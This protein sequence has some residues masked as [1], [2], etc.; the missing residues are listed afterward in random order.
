MIHS[1]NDRVNSRHSSRPP[2]RAVDLANEIEFLQSVYR[3]YTE[4]IH[5]SQTD[6]EQVLFGY[7]PP[8]GIPDLVV[9]VMTHWVDRIDRQLDALV[10][11]SNAYAD[12]FNQRGFTLAELKMV[13]KG[14]VAETDYL[15]ERAFAY[16]YIHSPQE[17]R[18]FI[19]QHTSDDAD[20]SF[21]DI[22]LQL[23]ESWTKKSIPPLH[24]FFFGYS[25]PHYF[26]LSSMKRH[27]WILGKTGSGKSEIIKN[28][29]FH[30]QKK[31]NAKQDKSLVCIE[32]Q[33][34]LSVELLQ[35]YLNGHNKER[36]VYL[37][38]HIRETAKQLL[39]RDI[40]DQDYIFK[41]NPLDLKPYERTEQNIEYLTD[42]LTGVF[43]ELLKSES[44]SQMEMVLAACI[45]ALLR[46][47]DCDI[48]DLIHFM[49]D[50][51]NEELVE[52]GS[53]ID[54]VIHA[55]TIADMRGTTFNSTKRPVRNR[56]SKIVGSKNTLAVFTGKSSV[57][58]G[59][60][61]EKGKVI[62][63]NLKQGL[64]SEDASQTLGKFLVA[65][66]QTEIKKR[67][68]GS[69]PKPT[70][71]VLDEAQ[72]FITE[73][74][75]NILSKERQK[76]LHMILAHQYSDQIQSA[77]IK[78]GVKSNTCIKVSSKND[79]ASMRTMASAMGLKTT[80]FDSLSKLGKYYFYVHDNSSD[81]GARKFKAPSKY[82][83]IKPPFYL[84]KAELEELFL[85]LVHESG[86]YVPLDGTSKPKRKP[87]APPPADIDKY[88]Q[89]GKPYQDPFSSSQ[90]H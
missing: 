61:I 88:N 18:F 44:S 76:G 49:N 11:Y 75:C 84:D 17:H 86:Y 64:L 70:F 12:L 15:A 62:I 36:I 50:N 1:Y 21:L 45:N 72:D 37:D 66:I 4:S 19:A 35:F 9:Q 74:V 55:Q 79:D 27:T 7:I 40:F 25:V 30:L 67:P 52:R 83:D 54:N 6:D 33:G 59:Q 24:E 89:G 48:L 69:R 80:D 32:P 28:I 43:F 10:E 29:W 56:L 46:M 82:V 47:G 81:T 73:K 42:Q 14:N 20:K 13:L 57:R 23:L 8:F 51:T 3:Q 58:I 16:L 85:W 22:F 90:N 26:P 78:S 71:V 34:K 60:E 53:K 65:L 63:C 68:V 39:G 77:T 31:S 38:T 5:P 41:I 87:T 2:H